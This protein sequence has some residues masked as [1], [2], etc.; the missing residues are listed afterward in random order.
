MKTEF[1][2]QFY[3]DLDKLPTS[4]KDDVA[5]AIENVE[6]ASRTTEIKNLKKIVGYIGYAC[7]TFISINQRDKFLF[8]KSIIIIRSP[9]GLTQFFLFKLDA[10]DDIN[11]AQNNGKQ[12]RARRFYEKYAVEKKENAPIQRMPHHFV[13]PLSNQ[14][15]WRFFFGAQTEKCEKI[16]SL[17]G[18]NHHIKPCHEQRSTHVLK[19]SNTLKNI[20]RL[21]SPQFKDDGKYEQ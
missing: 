18:G 5:N 17:E 12:D 14:A 15:R 16:Y 4:V 7:L 19:E 21:S 11:N 6:A 9:V 10:D 2:K 3:K 1:L 8:L 20:F 13:P